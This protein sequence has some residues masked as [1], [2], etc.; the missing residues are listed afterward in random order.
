MQDI[1]K[2]MSDFTFPVHVKEW[3][4]GKKRMGG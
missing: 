1:L 2:E 4:Q 3:W